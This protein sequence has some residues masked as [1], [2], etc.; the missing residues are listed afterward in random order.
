[1]TGMRL[2]YGHLHKESINE[3][4]PGTRRH[5]EVDVCHAPGQYSG[6]TRT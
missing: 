4:C 2:K 3:K 5:L 6:P 1:M